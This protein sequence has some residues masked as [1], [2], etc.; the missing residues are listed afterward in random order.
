MSATNHPYYE[1]AA[2]GVPTS[3]ANSNIA[4]L[5]S[6]YTRDYAAHTAAI[7]GKRPGDLKEDLTALPHGKR[8]AATLD[9]PQP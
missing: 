5:Q 4:L 8:N 6:R 9:N 2:Y 3:A 7:L 1:P